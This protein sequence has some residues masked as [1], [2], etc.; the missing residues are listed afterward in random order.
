MT[1]ELCRGNVMHARFGAAANR[2]VYP[3]FFVALPLSQ[4]ERAASRWFGID[5]PGLLSLRY[6]DHGA[7]DGSPPLPWI[8]AVLAR[9]G[10]DRADGEV[11]LQA[12]PRVLGLVFN[13]V[14][15]WFCHDREGNLRAVLAEVNNTFGE[16]HN[17]L[18]A[19]ADQRPI[20]PA[21]HLVARKVFHVSPFFSVGG[22]YRF[23][24]DLTG[25]RRRVQIDYWKDGQRVL[26]TSVYGR[27]ATLDAHSALRAGL[28]FPALALGV[29]ARIH[30]QALRLWL[31][32]ATFFR[33]PPVPLQ[34]TTR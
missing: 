29:V 32:G 17:Y 21:D 4:L 14:S 10:I 22:E 3:L 6:A 12:F 7:R 1:P 26:A 18:V 34:E 33:K 15:F 27:S 19:H 2:F 28:S 11:V 9:E 30:W 24:F 16:R 31:K 20:E 5:R 23:R 13:P 25:G 8:R